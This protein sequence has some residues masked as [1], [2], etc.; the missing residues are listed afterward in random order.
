MKGL[1][2]RFQLDG[3]VCSHEPVTGKPYEAEVEE[4]HIL[5]NPRKT[6]RAYG[7]QRRDSRGNV[8]TDAVQPDPLNPGKTIELTTIFDAATCS[9][10]LASPDVGISQAFLLPR[11]QQ[12]VTALLASQQEPPRSPP[13]GAVIPGFRPPHVETLGERVVEGV[14]CTGSRSTDQSSGLVCEH[15]VSRDLIIG[16]LYVTRDDEGETLFRLFNLRLS[17]PDPAFFLPLQDHLRK[18]QAGS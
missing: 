15:W 4:V 16:L 12:E 1:L 9:I 18:P 14:I 11:S 7:T 10:Y 2:E 5:Y 6:A 3:R 13:P 17:E 8:R